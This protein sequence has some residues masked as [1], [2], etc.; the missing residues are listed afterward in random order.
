MLRTI[1]EILHSPKLPDILLIY[2]DEEFLVEEAYRRIYEH[3]ASF[4]FSDYDIEMLDG[5]DLTL[6]RLVDICQSYPFISERKIVIVRNFDEL[7]S[8]TRKKT[9]DASPFGR[10]L[11]NPSPSTFLLLI[12]EAE[13]LAGLKNA[14]Q[15]QKQDAKAKK[16]IDSAKFPFGVIA[17]DYDYIEYPKVYE[18]DFSD[19]VIRRLKQRGKTISAP[20]LDLL[21]SQTNPTLRELANEVE[22]CLIYI[23]EK[24]EITY[25]DVIGLVGGSR[26]HN[27][28]ELQKAVGKKDLP[29]TI[30]ILENMLAVDRA[31]MLIITV[32]MR[33]FVALWKIMESGLPQGSN[34]YQIASAAG[35]NPYFV[36]DYL[37]ALKR[38]TP[39]QLDNAF[40]LL[41]EADDML[42]SSPASS[43][44]VLE[45]M[46]VKLIS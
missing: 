9:D 11:K 22:K 25:E 26:Q 6:L 13:S 43:L 7:F 24:K 32:L 39:D 20:A 19:F 29:R 1:D 37:D 18:S 38:Y 4:G 28:F 15:K 12:A 35:I 44:A 3:I 31:E 14:Q 10:Y 30:D 2:G 40:V 16:I 5:S 17:R 8:G 23:G 42:K 41:C 27:V 46:F 21:L 34:Q 33:Y 36:N 45:Q